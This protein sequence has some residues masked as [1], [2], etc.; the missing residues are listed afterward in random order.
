MSETTVAAEA[1]APVKRV[2]TLPV[3][4]LQAN[5]S[6]LQYA[7]WYVQ[8]LPEG[9]EFED[10][11]H[12]FYWVHHTKRIHRFSLV[13]VRAAD[14]SWDVM[15]RA[16]HIEQGGGIQMELYPRYPQELADKAGRPEEISAAASDIT[17]AAAAATMPREINGQPVPRIDFTKSTQWRLIGLT[18]TPIKGK[19]GMTKPQAEKALAAYKAAM[20]L[21]D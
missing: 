19:D 5:Y 7:T 21:P 13:R 6:G 3:N 17:D 4:Y 11:F 14:G 15:V 1:A 9:H 2:R 12:P 8:G 18:G 10:I 20:K 16:S